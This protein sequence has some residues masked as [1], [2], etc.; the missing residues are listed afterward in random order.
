MRSVRPDVPFAIDDA[1]HRALQ[2]AADQRFSSAAEFAAA[3]G[4]TSDSPS[5]IIVP[6][7]TAQR[8]GSMNLR[9]IT[10]IVTAAAAGAAALWFARGA[11][12]SLVSGTP[13]GEIMRVAID[14]AASDRDLAISPDGRKIVAQG[15]RGLEWLQVGD[16]RFQPIAGTVNAASPFFSPSGEVIAFIQGRQLRVASLVGGDN[17]PIADASWGGG[18]WG[19]NDTIIY[20]PHAGSGL[21][22]VAAQGGQPHPLISPHHER[23]EFGLWWPDLLPGGRTVIFTVYINP[24]SRS[25]VDAYNLDTKQRK[26]LIEDAVDGTFAP[27]DHLLFIRPS[28]PATVLVG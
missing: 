1:L 24:S 8:Q 2:A 4:S 13:T 19:A 12:R 11:I 26:T 9:R 23:K 28:R 6:A 27:P 17:K 21:W 15:G 16:R 25:H 22:E 5:T 18:V 14:A 20:T 3:L 7:S 10:L